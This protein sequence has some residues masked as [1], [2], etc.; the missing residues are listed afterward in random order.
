MSKYKIK[1]KKKKSIL[2]MITWSLMIVLVVGRVL[3]GVHWLTDII[4]SVIISAFL[5]SLLLTCIKKIKK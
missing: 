4:G 5:L 3:S 1:K 2:D